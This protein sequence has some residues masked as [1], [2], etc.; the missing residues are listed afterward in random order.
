MAGCLNERSFPF[1]ESTLMELPAPQ[2]RPQPL[3]TREWLQSAHKQFRSLLPKCDYEPLLTEDLTNADGR[4]VDVFAHFDKDPAYLHTAI[5]NLSGL[6]HTAQV[7]GSTEAIEIPAPEWPG[8]EDVWID[9]EPGVALSARL[10]VAK[11]DGKPIDSD[12]IVLLPGLLGDNMRLRTRDICMGLR[13]AGFHTLALEFRGHGQAEA[14]HP[15]VFYNFGALETPDMMVVAEWLQDKPY[16]RRTGIVGFSWSA[17]IA[18]LSAWEDGRAVDDPMVSSRLAE[19]QSRF[20]RSRRHYEAGI[21]AISP[22]VD[23]ENLL[24]RLE[25]P[26]TFSENPVLSAIQDT[27]ARRVARKNHGPKTGSLRKLIEYEF[28][29]ST[30]DYPGGV[31]DGVNYL[32]LSPYKDEPYTAKLVSARVPVLIIHGANDPVAYAQEIANFISET[33]NPNVA[34]VMLHGGGHD[35]FAAY[36]PDYLYSMMINFFSAE[37]GPRVIADH[38]QAHANARG[39]ATMHAVIQQSHGSRR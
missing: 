6:V 35:G 36:C 3:S 16:I 23:F 11:R 5:G 22:T 20:D 10:G 18:L 13:D 39:G 8:F 37:R 19:R 31:T 14:K 26:H 24:D 33:P 38:A 4:P 32:R 2:T 25:T 21:F 27:V 7:T 30:V 17:N 15:E 9:V 12:C 28:A 29:R 34:C 1:N